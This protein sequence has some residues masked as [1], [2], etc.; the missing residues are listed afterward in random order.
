MRTNLSDLLYC[1]ILI[2]T[3][4]NTNQ[5]LCNRVTRGGLILNSSTTLH[6]RIYYSTLAPFYLIRSRERAKYATVLHSKIV[7]C[8]VKSRFHRFSGRRT[9]KTNFWSDFPHEI[10]LIARIFPHS[11][12][13][14][15]NTTQLAKYPRVLYVKPSNKMY[16]LYDM[17]TCLLWVHRHHNNSYDHN[18]NNL[19]GE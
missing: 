10:F 19:H 4:S 14:R 16:V 13:A 5:C 9:A 6:Y 17:L 8:T 12:R 18:K 15:K 11:F 7:Y 2:K 1:C 3:T